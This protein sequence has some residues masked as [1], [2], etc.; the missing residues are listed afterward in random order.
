MRSIMSPITRRLLLACC[1]LA[2]LTGCQAEKRALRTD[3]ADYN[4]ILQHNQSEQMLL[5]IVRMHYREVPFFMKAGT[6][7]ASY[8][9]SVSTGVD[10]TLQEGEQSLVGVSGR[11][12]FSSKPTVSYTPVEGKEFVQQL[13]EEISPHTFALLL[14]AGW[15]V[16]MLG[17]LLVERVTLDGGE[18]LVGRPSSPSFAKFREFMHA[19][20]KAEDADGLKVVTRADGGLNLE[21][22][23]KSVGVER[24]QLRSLY[25]AMFMASKDVETPEAK[26]GEMKPSVGTGEMRIRASEKPLSGALVSV[27]YRGWH[28]SIAADDIRSKDT[29][30]LF[31]QLSRIQSGPP[32]APPTLTIPAR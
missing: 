2:A 3:F 27:E 10:A 31:M 6:L 17:D 20:E 28:Y 26:K 13:M 29:L 11:Y 24:F 18:L 16:Q 19:I 5:N 22:D 15:S 32:T 1:S 21:F 12:S 7:T 30:A 14:R 9:T 8:D 23:G 4:A 25:S